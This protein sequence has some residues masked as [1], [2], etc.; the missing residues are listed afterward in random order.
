[1]MILEAFY[2]INNSMI[3]DS[4][5]MGQRELSPKPAG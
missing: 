1:M 2:N 5:M 3:R 4:M